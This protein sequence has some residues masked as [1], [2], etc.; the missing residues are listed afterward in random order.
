[1]ESASSDGL[2]EVEHFKSIDLL[3]RL[4]LDPRLESVGAV[5]LLLRGA[6]GWLSSFRRDSECS[7]EYF[8]SKT[9]LMDLLLLPLE[10]LLQFAGAVA[11]FL[12]E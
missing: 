3:L 2:T 8:P 12:K 9:T 11:L 4:V 5:A 7:S 10:L 6:F 1:M